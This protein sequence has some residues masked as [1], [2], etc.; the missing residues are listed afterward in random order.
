MVNKQKNKVVIL[1]IQIELN[2]GYRIFPST[3]WLMQEKMQY[4]Y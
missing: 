4:S 1:V 2:Q 3:L